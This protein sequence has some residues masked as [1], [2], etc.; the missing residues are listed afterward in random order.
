MLVMG[1]AAALLFAGY[2]QAHSWF[3]A[4]TVPAIFSLQWGLAMGLPSAVAIHLL[5]R[6]APK[7]GAFAWRGPLA[8]LG[9]WLGLTLAGVSF[10]AAIQLAIGLP[11]W[12]DVTGRL[13]ERMH[14]LLPEVAALAAFVICLLLRHRAINQP[15]R[16]ADREWICFPQAPALHLQVADIRYIRSAGNYCEIHANGR[17]HLVR[18]TMAQAAERLQP[19]GF[20]RIHRTL[21]VDIARIVEIDR[22]P[23]ER[24]PTVR[25]ASGERLPVGS[26]YAADVIDRLQ[27]AQAQ[28]L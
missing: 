20:V 21:I 6:Q 25:I 15:S 22:G 13:L 17:T 27:L 24:S 12:Q 10:G 26:A 4:A 19:H 11:D 16:N 18:M 23:R 9:L 2:C 5:W 14:D 8:M 28:Q 3:D 7:L 1:F